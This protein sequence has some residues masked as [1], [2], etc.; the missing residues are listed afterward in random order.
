V[1]I[2]LSPSNN[3]QNSSHDYRLVQLS[4]FL[5][6]CHCFI[7]PV[8]SNSNIQHVTHF[9]PKSIISSSSFKSPQVTHFTHIFVWFMYIHS[10]HVYIR[11]STDYSITSCI[12]RNVYI[13]LYVS[14]WYDSN[15]DWKENSNTRCSREV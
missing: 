9:S 11:G 4:Y 14:I 7:S 2:I 5:F 12:Y 10:S 1:F 13:M 8:A 15:Q 6:G 3:C